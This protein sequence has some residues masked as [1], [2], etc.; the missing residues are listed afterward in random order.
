MRKN[1]IAGAAIL[2]LLMNAPQA[3]AD[4][5]VVFGGEFEEETPAQKPVEKPAPI[6]ELP[7]EPP[8]IE[9][10]APVEQ[11]APPEEK[12]EVIEQQPPTKPLEQPEPPQAEQPAQVE[13]QEEVSTASPEDED[14]IGDT[15]IFDDLTQQPNRQ[16]VEQPQPS[17]IDEPTQIEEPQVEPSL[18]VEEIEHPFGRPSAT[19]PPTPEFTPPQSTAPATSVREQPS[20]PARRYSTPR[21]TQPQKDLKTLKPRF[22]KLAVD[23]TYTYYL[24]KNSV[25]WTKMPYS[26]SEYI[27]DVWIRMIERTPREL[28][29]DMAT[30]GAENF[31]AE[32]SLARE[33]GYQ[34]AAEDLQVL[35]SQAYVLEHYY[36]RP[37]TKQIQFLCELEVFGRPQNTVSERAYDYRNWENLVPGSVESV[38]YEATIKIIGTW[39]STERGHMTFSDMLDEYLRIV[40]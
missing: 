29:D 16:P 18:P 5:I 4:E 32:V 34:Y 23:D 25:Q 33:Q 13:Q 1:L 21:T 11:P 36:L 31:S 6:K 17:A 8:P 38:I 40:L 15:L 20:Q 30:Y 26:T 3:K 27:A 14:D 24:D 28:D 37:K 2:A 19:V 7:P 35:R 22:V 9:E 10:P 39:K 12:P